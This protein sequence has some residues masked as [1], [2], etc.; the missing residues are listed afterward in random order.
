[1]ARSICGLL[2]MLLAWPAAAQDGRYDVEHAPATLQDLRSRC[3]LARVITPC[4]LPADDLRLLER[5]VQ[6]DRL[7]QHVLASRLAAGRGFAGSDG[8]R[9]AIGWFGRSAEQGNPEAA[10]RYNDLRSDGLEPAADEARIASGLRQAAQAGSTAAQMALSEM[11]LYGRGTVRD[12]AG[13]MQLLRQAADSGD[14]R[15]RQLLGRRLTVGAPG[16]PPDRA[17]V[18]EMHR[19]AASG[20]D[21]PAMAAL[22]LMLLDGRGAAP[23]P[24]EGYR[25][26]MRAAHL[27]HKPAL[28]RVIQLFDE[29]LAR[30]GR[31]IVAPDPV[32]AYTWILIAARRPETRT[33]AGTQAR[34]QGTMASA[35]LAEAR[36]R[37]AS[38]RP[39]TPA[40]ATTAAFELPPVTAEGEARAIVAALSG[41]ARRHFELPPGVTPLPWQVVPDF[42]RAA[43]VAAAIG[44]ISRYCEAQGHSLCVSVCRANAHAERTAD[45]PRGRQRWIEAWQRCASGVGI[46]R[47]R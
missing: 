38:W 47:F 40:E 2:V 1:M 18:I 33:A 17:A 16:V 29:G 32:Q 41:D 22:G 30:D 35:D 45:D 20:G 10:L 37:A 7:A 34:L 3:G 46:P 14:R 21:A 9:S 24:A 12:V 28:E 11:M 4:P 31:I 8:R 13:S 5:A 27:E 19:R 15:A 43:D 23:D 25:W 44:A 6:G 39:L 42:D 36:S 26:L